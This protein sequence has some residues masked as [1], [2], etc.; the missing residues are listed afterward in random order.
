M[1]PNKISALNS[2]AFKKLLKRR[3]KMEKDKKNECAEFFVI[4]LS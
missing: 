1:H 4:F 2:T 3:K